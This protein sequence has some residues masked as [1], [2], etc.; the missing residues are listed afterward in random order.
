MNRYL[1]LAIS[2]GTL[3]FSCKKN[4]LITPKAGN[5]IMMEITTVN[6]TVE[7]F[8][9]DGEEGKSLLLDLDGDN[10]VDVDFVS[11][12]LPLSGS[13]YYSVRMLRELNEQIDF[14]I[15]DESDELWRGEGITGRT[16]PLGW[17]IWVDTVGYSCNNRTGA[18]LEE[19]TPFARNFPANEKID[20]KNYNW[21]DAENERI[22]TKSSYIYQYGEFADDGTIEYKETHYLGGCHDVP[23]N[24]VVYLIFRIGSGDTYKVG[25]IEV[26]LTGE[27][28]IAILRTAISKKEYTF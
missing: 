23:T 15:V 2:C 3:F 9:E 13:K 18:I 22:L 28:K 17:I 19:T 11:Q 21:G 25:W 26:D 6:K 1:L 16:D 10:V 7:G 4:P 27:N 8:L 5:D 20:Y 12:Q 14:T 24:E